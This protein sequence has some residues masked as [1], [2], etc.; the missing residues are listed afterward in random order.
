MHAIS[1]IKEIDI[2][3]IRHV[4]PF[5]IYHRTLLAQQAVTQELYT[6]PYGFWYHMETVTATWPESIDLGAPIGLVVRPIV[7]IAITRIGV[8]QKA[9]NEPIPIT[10]ISSPGSAGVMDTPDGIEVAPLTSKK[11]LNVL[12]PNNDTIQYQL[13]DDGTWAGEYMDLCIQGYLIP[14]KA[15]E[16]WKGM[17]RH[18]GNH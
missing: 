6:I 12:L 7:N 18:A 2:E 11:Q 10:L 17:Q 3:K 5:W 9:Q 14:Q 1:K 15:L 4:S 16:M 8:S 13:Y